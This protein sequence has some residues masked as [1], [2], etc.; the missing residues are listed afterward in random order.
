MHD[1]SRGIVIEID[2][3]KMSATLL[4]DTPYREAAHHIP[5]K[6]SFYPTP[7]C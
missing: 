1:E 2:E 5:G 7:T 4:R 3:E 6:R